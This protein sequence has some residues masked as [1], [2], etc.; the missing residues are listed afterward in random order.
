MQTTNALRAEYEAINATV[1]SLQRRMSEIAL[2]I[3]AEED[4]EAGYRDRK[5][6]YYDKWYRR[7]RPDEGTAYDRGVVACV[8][9]GDV[10]PDENFFLVEC[11]A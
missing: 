5:A 4:F 8:N 3:H 1:G 6:G 7:F 9:A 2:A 10:D 11:R